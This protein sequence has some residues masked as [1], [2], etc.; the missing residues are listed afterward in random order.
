MR[1]VS[2]LLFPALMIAVMALSSLLMAGVVAAQAAANEY[3]PV[4]TSEKADPNIFVDYNGQRIHF[5]CN[6][7]KRDFLE[8]PDRYLANLESGTEEPVQG[9]L[10]STDG[11]T[12]APAT[13]VKASSNG[14][15]HG[16]ADTVADSNSPGATRAAV[17]LHIDTNSTGTHGGETEATSEHDHDEDHGDQTGLIGF[18]GKFH[19]VIIH[20]PIALVIMAAVFVLSRLVSGREF[21]DPM[22]VI[23]MYWAAIFAILAA[24][25]GLARASGANFPSFLDEYFEWHRLLGLAS[26][27][28]TTITAV[29]GYVWRHNGSRKAMVL[30]R[31][32]LAVNVI[33]IG[34]TGHL[35]ATLVYGPN[36]YS[37]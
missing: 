6:K 29:T 19:P 24:L 11:S 15:E 23:T 30:F 37:S 32:L 35:G 18:L 34:I 22:A 13:A 25:L 17:D 31:I 20:F 21:F 16:S 3:C 27:G 26:A 1:R 28:L 10:A 8:D 9:N 36:Y 2:L 5:C 33:L 12:D 4:T 14:G 7:C